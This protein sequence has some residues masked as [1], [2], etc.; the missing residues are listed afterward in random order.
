MTIFSNT[1]GL[2]MRNF[3]IYPEMP[4]P[5]ALIAYAREAE[6]LGFDSV[7]VWDHILLGVDPPFPVLDSLT[8]LTGQ[9]NLRL[10]NYLFTLE[11]VRRVK[12]IL[13]PGGTFFLQSKS[14]SVEE[15][16][17]AQLL[18]RLEKLTKQVELLSSKQKG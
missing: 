8:L 9:G 7:W 14:P 18:D 13:E 16:R 5:Q 10:E 2:A 3:T 6:A 4:D 1:F 17:H 15:S 12:S 11:S